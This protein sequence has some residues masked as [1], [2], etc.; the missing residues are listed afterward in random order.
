[1]GENTSAEA[2][3]TFIADCFGL[4]CSRVL[5]HVL[6]AAWKVPYPVSLRY[7]GLALVANGVALHLCVRTTD[8]TSNLLLCFGVFWNYFQ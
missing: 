3:I 1:V 2:V 5:C 8:D 4:L 6:H 7:V